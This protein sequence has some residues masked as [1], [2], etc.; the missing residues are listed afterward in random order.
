MVSVLRD[1]QLFGRK[2]ET[3][4]FHWQDSLFDEDQSFDFVSWEREQLR[5]CMEIQHQYS[6]KVFNTSDSDITYDSD[7]TYDPEFEVLTLHYTV[8]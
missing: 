1:M 7:E 4:L 3:E 8:L 6:D 2:G 5:K